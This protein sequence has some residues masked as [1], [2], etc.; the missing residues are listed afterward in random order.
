MEQKV[1][2]KQNVDSV[3]GH[4][5]Q[6]TDYDKFKL[7]DFNR[8]INNNHVNNLIESFQDEAYLTIPILVNEKFEIIDGQHR[9]TAASKLGL[10]IYYII[11]PNYGLQEIHTLNTSMKNWGK[12]DFLESYT[13]EG[14][15]PYVMMTNFM[16]RFPQFNLAST[17]AIL[18][19]VKDLEGNNVMMPKK[20]FEKGL[21]IFPNYNK[22][23]EIAKYLLDFSE[24]YTGF[25]RKSFVNAF[26]VI[27]SHANYSHERMLE[28]FRKYGKT[29]I[30][31]STEKQYI[32]ALEDLFNH[33]RSKKE[34]KTLKY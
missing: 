24:F 34:G 13:E 22:S 32:N 18:T 11:Q 25:N 19:K 23:V 28:Q 30:H 5:F 10:P 16:H 26:I 20:S 15:N 9:F 29:F 31:Y 33:K 8:P 4:I 6:E 21:L 2:I 12:K 1:Q 7:I 3:V 17:E 14:L 27:E